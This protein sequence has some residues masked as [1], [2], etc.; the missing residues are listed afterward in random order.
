MIVGKDEFGQKY[1]YDLPNEIKTA[2]E[3]ES[4]DTGIILATK[5]AM[6]CRGNRFC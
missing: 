5:P 6:N 1:V 4:L 2:A 3:F